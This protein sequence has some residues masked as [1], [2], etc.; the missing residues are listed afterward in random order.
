MTSDR[1]EVGT[2]LPAGDRRDVLKGALNAIERL[3]GRIEAADYARHE[4]IAIVGMS[5]RLPGGVED[6]EA[7]W[8]VLAEG[9]DVISEVPADRWDV[10]AYHS[11]DPAAPGKAY[12]KAGG[13]LSRIDEFDPGFFGMSPR[14]AVGLDPQQRLLLEVAWEA[15]EDA[16]IPADQL[17]GSLTG[18]FVGIT[19]TDYAGRIDIADPARSDI[20]L[21]TG[22]ALNAAAGRVSFTFGFRGPCMAIDTACSSSLVAIHAACQ[23]LRNR[24]SN[25]VLAGGVNCLLAPD[26][27]VLISKW[28]MLSPDGRCKTFDASANG[29]VRAEGCGMLVLERLSDALIK[30]RRVLAVIRG[31]AINQD[32][33][34][35]GLTVPNGLAQQEVVRSALAAARLKPTDVSYVE[36]HGT[37]T[38]LGDPIEVEALAAVYGDGRPGDQPLE[39]GSVKSNIGHLEAASG[40]ASVI[41]LVMALKNRQIPASLHVTQL[42]PAIPWQAIPVSVSTRLHEWRGDKGPRT[43][44]VSAFGFSGMNAH[45]LVQEAP[46]PASPVVPA[47]QP[48]RGEHV[49]PLSAKSELALRELAARHA[50]YL[51]R[52][53]GVSLEEFCATVANGRSH[54][55]VRCALVAADRGEMVG[56]LRRLAAGDE[57][58][59]CGTAP[60]GARLRVAFLFTGQGS[61]YAGMARELDASEPVFRAML[62]RCSAVL[63]PLLG[64]PL[65]E[66]L[67]D[68]DDGSLNNTGYAQ[69]A[70]YAVEIALAALWRSWGIEPS[71]VIGHSVGEFAAAAVAGVVSIED[72]ARLIAARAN[73]MQALPSGGAML[74][75][76]GDPSAIQAA[77]S[78]FGGKLSLAAFNAPESVVLSGDAESI[79]AIAPRLAEF[80]SIVKPLHVSHAFHSHLMEPMLEPFRVAAE[81]FD[82]AAPSLIWISTFTGEPLDW[83]AWGTKMP[84]YWKR[85]VREPVHFGKAIKTALDCNADIFVEIGPHPSL[86]ALANQCVEPATGPECLPSM[87][88]GAIRGSWPD[89]GRAASETICARCKNRLARSRIASAGTKHPPANLSVPAQALS[90]AA[91]APLFATLGSGGASFARCPDSRRRCRCPVRA[92]VGSGDAGLGRGPSHQLADSDADDWNAGSMSGCRQAR[93]R[94]H[95]RRPRKCGDRC[96][97]RIAL[98]AQ[99][100]AAGGCR[101]TD[102]AARMRV[103]SAAA[104]SE[105]TVTRGRCI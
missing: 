41:K 103:W 61:Q 5:C 29:F 21:A 55:E 91:E 43:A 59:S 101:C 2:P 87:R 97:P 32:G 69:P 79:S 14:E 34:S 95:G 102:P 28:G 63:D 66:I 70:L 72:G 64:R 16:A 18:V 7:Y 3:Q 47:H 82:H 86:S 85:Q 22:T 49:L 11:T 54:L 31:S 74:S 75:V 30:G 93:D 50:D 73:L 45:L 105:S 78:E 10:G 27:F 26:P 8:R 104:R 37:G 62:E 15:L 89:A 58:I 90:G 40:V 52:E 24:E 67:F 33:R 57:G 48:L 35:S 36:A 4:P 46:V 42:S 92:G 84:D 17:E 99:A 12:T 44:G 53:A 81:A 9:R 68:L 38:S 19:S 88:R 6:P 56:E 60:P 77:A 1:D 51:E 20:Y 76:Q 13:F 94:L 71:I 100:D 83:E 25:L 98:R 65:R 23:S 39:I 80:G 96:A